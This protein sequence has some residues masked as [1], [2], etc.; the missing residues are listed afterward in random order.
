MGTQT[1]GAVRAWQKANGLPA[2]GYLTVDLSHRLQAQAGIS[3]TGN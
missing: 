1:R 2:D 3:A